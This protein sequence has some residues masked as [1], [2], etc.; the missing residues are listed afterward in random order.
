MSKEQKIGSDM[1]KIS[2]TNN[3]SA[4]AIEGNF[5]RVVFGSGLATLFAELE[6]HVNFGHCNI[7]VVIFEVELQ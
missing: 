3:Y 2:F 6:F 5:L 1:Y 7:Y 4:Q